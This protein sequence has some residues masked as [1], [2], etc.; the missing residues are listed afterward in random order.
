MCFHGCSWLFLVRY[1]VLTTELQNSD[2]SICVQDSPPVATWMVSTHGKTN[3]PELCAPL[4]F[5]S[6]LKVFIMKVRFQHSAVTTIPGRFQLLKS[7][8][9]VIEMDWEW[10]GIVSVDAKEKAQCPNLTVHFLC[11]ISCSVPQAFVGACEPLKL[12]RFREPRAR[13]AVLVGTVS[14]LH[15]W[16]W[17][18]PSVH[19]CPGPECGGEGGPDSHHQV[20]HLLPEQAG[21]DHLSEAFAQGKW[22]S[23]FFVYL[24]VFYQLQT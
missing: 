1:T 21:P 2:I 23:L 18:L 9:L 14:P 16:P 7:G 5:C 17:T 11:R 8:G 10:V 15:R 22:K 13:R 3:A 12:S 4:S 24:F 6:A 19:R 20:P